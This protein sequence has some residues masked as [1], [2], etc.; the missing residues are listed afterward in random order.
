ME[1]E[2]L[3]RHSQ[4]E[5]S[6]ELEP[7]IERDHDPMDSVI[8][9]FSPESIERIEPTPETEQRQIPKLDRPIEQNPNSSEIADLSS[10]DNEIVDQIRK[11]DRL[12]KPPAKFTY[13][14]LGKPLIL[15]AQTILDGF[16]K[17]LIETFEGASSFETRT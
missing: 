1:E 7:E 2:N 6:T 17:A 15:F 4:D 11:S 3:T 5:T 10:N 8:D 12:R 16:N 9:Q 13:P 14:Q